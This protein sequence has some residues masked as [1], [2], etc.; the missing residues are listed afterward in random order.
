MKKISLFFL[1]LI[2][3]SCALHSKGEDGKPGTNGTNESNGI[4]GTNGKDGKAALGLN[5]V[6]KDKPKEI[7][8]EILVGKTQ[9]KD[10][11]QEPFKEWFENG[12]TDYQP[13]SEIMNSLKG[14]NF[15]YTITIFMATW[16]EDSQNQVPKFYKI[17][18]EINF[19]EDKVTLITMLRDKTTPEAF[20]KEL[21]ITN[22]P[23]FIFFENGKELNRIVESPVENLEKD[24]VTILSKKPYRHIY[25]E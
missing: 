15:N 4:D 11:L 1:L 14:I 9:K 5:L 22:V 3:N 21:N 19:P 7:G 17:L 18:N 16:C 13:D 12:F 2:I 25:S 20:E 8:D 24:M 10:L 6:K 23:T